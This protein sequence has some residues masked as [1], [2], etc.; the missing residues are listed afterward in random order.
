M[1]LNVM[2]TENQ[3]EHMKI[4]IGSLDQKSPEKNKWI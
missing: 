4:S 2:W 1:H 3:M